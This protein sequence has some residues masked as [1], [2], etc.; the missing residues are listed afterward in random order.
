MYVSNEESES[1]R[2]PTVTLTLDTPKV[3]WLITVQG[4]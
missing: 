3:V 2:L 4:Y 1:P